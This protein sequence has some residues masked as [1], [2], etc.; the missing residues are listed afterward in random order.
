MKE[1][2]HFTR[3]QI[4]TSSSWQIN[5]LSKNHGDQRGQGGLGAHLYKGIAGR[6]WGDEVDRQIEVGLGSA[7]CATQRA[8][9]SRLEILGSRKYSEQQ[10]AQVG[11]PNG[12]VEG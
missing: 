10:R 4:G 2:W 8:L 11:H 1:N 5:T 3:S 9:D 7:E 6:S 12:R